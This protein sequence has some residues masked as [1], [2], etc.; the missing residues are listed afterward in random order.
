MLSGRDIAFFVCF[1]Y[2]SSL[3]DSDCDLSDETGMFVVNHTRCTAFFVRL[4]DIIA[5]DSNENYIWLCNM[6]LQDGLYLEGGDCIS[7]GVVLGDCFKV[8]QI[9]VELIKDHMPFYCEAKVFTKCIPYKEGLDYLDDDTDD[10]VD[11]AGASCNPFDA[12]NGIIGD[13]GE[14]DV[15]GERR[16]PVDEDR[17]TKRLRRSDHSILTISKD[18]QLGF[19]SS[20]SHH[21]LVLTLL[22]LRLHPRE[23]QTMSFTSKIC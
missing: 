8:H 21:M 13:Y 22:R 10:S 18:E 15:G 2:S 6:L 20:P 17:P 12:A 9:G 23:D 11:E 19:T 5:T 1:V 7:L 4:W 3:S 16:D 14:D